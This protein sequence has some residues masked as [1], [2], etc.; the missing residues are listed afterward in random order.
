MAEGHREDD[1]AKV[2]AHIVN[3]IKGKHK[4]KYDTIILD[5]LFLFIYYR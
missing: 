2:L 4:L 5:K 1:P 3:E